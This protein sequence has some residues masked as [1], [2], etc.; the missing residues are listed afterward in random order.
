[1]HFRAVKSISESA[2]QWVVNSVVWMNYRRVIHT[3]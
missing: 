3:A 1:L 2:A